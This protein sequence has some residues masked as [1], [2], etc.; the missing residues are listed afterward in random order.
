[1]IDTHAAVRPH[2]QM[3]TRFVLI[4]YGGSE[5]RVDRRGDRGGA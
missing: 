5:H 1:M 4:S 2:A 3:K